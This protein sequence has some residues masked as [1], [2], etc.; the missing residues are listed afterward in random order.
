M[1]LTDVEF[2]TEFD[3]DL[4]P[5]CESSWHEYFNHT[6]PAVYIMRF[7]CLACTRSIHFLMCDPCYKVGL[8]PEAMVECVDCGTLQ[9]TRDAFRLVSTL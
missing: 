1:T 4:E 3:L 2:A 7:D 9:E 5:G 8:I 6:D